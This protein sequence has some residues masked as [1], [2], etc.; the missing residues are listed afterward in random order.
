MSLPIPLSVTLSTSRV[1]RRITSQVRDLSFRSAIPGGFASAQISLDRPLSIQPDEIAYYGRLMVH[2]TRNGQVVWEGLVQDPGRSAGVDGQVW[3]IA[4]IGPA[5]HARDVRAP[6]IYVYRDLSHW[7]RT[8]AT[9]ESGRFSQ[10]EHSDG[11]PALL[12]VA[13]TG[14]WNAAD[15]IRGTSKWVLEA[16]QNLARVNWRMVGGSGSANWL[17]QGFVWFGV[18]TEVRS[19]TLTSVEQG[20]SARVVGTHWTHPQ[21]RLDLR[22]RCDTAGQSG[23]DF[24]WARFWDVRV[25]AT[26]YNASGSEIVTGASYTSDNVTVAEVITDLLGRRL[27]LFDGPNASIASIAETIEQLAYTGG[28]TAS[29]VLDDLITLHPTFYWAAWERNAVSGKHRFEWVEWPD[30]VRYEADVNDGYTAPGSAEGLYDAVTVLWRDPGGT[31]RRTRVTSSVQSLTDAGITREDTL[32]LGAEVQSSG[33]ATVAGTQ[34]LADHA[35]PPNAGTLTIARPI[36][37]LVSGHVVAPWEI[38]PGSLIRVRG[39]LPRVGAL[40]ATSRD[41]V[42]IFRVVATTFRAQDASTTLELDTPAPSVSRSLADLSVRPI[43]EKRAP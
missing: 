15:N 2:D 24:R 19:T 12:M 14:T 7:Q 33:G 43:R 8:A 13:D 28:V 42:T 1:S 10:D 31:I 5:G 27:P 18:G 20:L 23:F 21:Q 9:K 6:L 30:E 36:L 39:I 4:A 35:E 34:W 3:D 16:G 37:D 38:R 32:S 22:L 25:R 40:N 41:G 29:E 17:M 11:S 26:L